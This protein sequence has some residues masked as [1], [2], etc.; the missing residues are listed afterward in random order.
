MRYGT[1]VSIGLEVGEKKAAGYCRDTWQGD[2]PG[3]MHATGEYCRSL[4]EDTCVHATPINNEGCLLSR[5]LSLSY[6]S[7]IFPLLSRWP[8]SLSIPNSEI[9]LTIFRTLRHAG[10]TENSAV[11][12]HPHLLRNELTASLTSTH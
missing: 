3:A 6:V 2:G 8:T 7:L 4:S 5:F 9:A 10:S 11:V 1:R 12:E